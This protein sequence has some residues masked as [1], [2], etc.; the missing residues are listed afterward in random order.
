MAVGNKQHKH[1]YIDREGER[2]TV[3]TY[4]DGIDIDYTDN[5]NK[6]PHTTYICVY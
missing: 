6:N 5:D 1:T 3:L 4:N 2:Y